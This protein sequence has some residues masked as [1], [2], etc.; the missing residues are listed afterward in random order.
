[1]IGQ[2]GQLQEWLQ[3]NDNPDCHHRHITNLYAVCQGR[4][5]DPVNTP[6]LADAAK[7]ALDM[8][9]DGRYPDQESA[10]GGNWSRCHRIW[11]WTRLADGNRANKIFT[12]MLSEEGFENLLT[13]QHA[14]WSPENR[15]LME[16]SLYLHFQMDACASVPG[17][18][19]EMLLQSHLEE[20]HILPAL[21]DEWPDGEITGL[22]ARGGYTVDISWKK[23]ELWKAVIHSKRFPVP[24]IRIRGKV[25]NPTEDKRITILQ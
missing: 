20:I 7:K 15:G 12:E 5:I 22:R 18:M 23:G 9:G 11:C 4:Q 14:E 6:Q 25:A 2:H 19:S 10:A 21:P 13:F 1:M 24:V 16:D 17:F 3:D 8:R